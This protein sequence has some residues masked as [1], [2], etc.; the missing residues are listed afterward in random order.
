LS[1]FKRQ[2]VSENIPLREIYAGIRWL[3]MKASKCLSRLEENVPRL[4]NVAGQQAVVMRRRMLCKKSIGLL[5]DSR[6]PLGE[7]QQG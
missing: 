6:S 4:E 3:E 7:V 1:S 5:E 2:I